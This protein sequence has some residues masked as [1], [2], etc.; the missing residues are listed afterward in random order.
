MA[1]ITAPRGGDR[2]GRNLIR[3]GLHQTLRQIIWEEPNLLQ[4]NMVT[5]GARLPGKLAVFTTLVSW[6]SIVVAN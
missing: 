3:E 6:L 4:V 2:I 5:A 1:E